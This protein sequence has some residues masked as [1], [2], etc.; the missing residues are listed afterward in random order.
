MTKNEKATLEAN[1]KLVWRIAI[2]CQESAKSVKDDAKEKAACAKGY[3]EACIDVLGYSY[4]GK[5][6]ATDAVQGW[7]DEA[8]QQIGA[9]LEL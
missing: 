6:G 9:K 1:L 2:N 3:R 7:I 4:D 5:S 8:E